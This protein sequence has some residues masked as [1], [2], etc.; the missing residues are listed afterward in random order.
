MRNT[1]TFSCYQDRLGSYDAYD[2]LDAQRE[3]YEDRRLG[4]LPPSQ[5]PRTPTQVDDTPPF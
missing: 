2:R 4:L 5:D 1:H 3:E